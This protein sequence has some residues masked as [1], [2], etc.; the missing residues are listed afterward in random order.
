MTIRNFIFAMFTF[1]MNIFSK[2]MN[3]KDFKMLTHASSLSQGPD[4]RNKGT[5][6]KGLCI[7]HFYILHFITHMHHSITGEGVV[8]NGAHPFL[9]F[10]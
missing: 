2:K 3:H 5:M 7:D 10:L 9:A 1:K 8:Q 4:S 6:S